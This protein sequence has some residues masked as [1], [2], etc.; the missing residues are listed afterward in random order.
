[1]VVLPEYFCLMGRRDEDKVALRERPGQGLIQ[2]F[3]RDEAKRH[4]LWLVGGTLPLE[5]PDSD[6]I[7]NTTLVY[8]PQGEQVV[9]Y[10]KIHWFG[11]SRGDESYDES[12]T[13]H[14]GSAQPSTFEPP[15]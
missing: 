9:R 7:C 10:D 3:L 12:R 4:G 15:C 6:R 14:P 11:F 13:I 8:N 2:D 1:M 5:S